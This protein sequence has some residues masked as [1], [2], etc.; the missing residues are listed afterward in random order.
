MHQET[1]RILKPNVIADDES[2]YPES[3]IPPPAAHSHNRLPLDGESVGRFNAGT[4]GPRRRV[5]HSAAGPSSSASAALHRPTT[6]GMS[7]NLQAP[8]PPTL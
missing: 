3:A 4:A 1:H 2:D 8:K 6:V 7:F 5:L